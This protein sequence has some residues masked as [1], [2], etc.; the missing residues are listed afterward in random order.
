MKLPEIPKGL[1]DALA[2]AFPD[3]APRNDLG[4][5]EFGR[6]AGPQEVLDVLRQSFKKQQETTHV[7]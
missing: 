1:L 2:K 5:F 3:E 6:R 4:A 7:H